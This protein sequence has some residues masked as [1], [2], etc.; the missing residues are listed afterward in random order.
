VFARE[1]RH[2]RDAVSLMGGLLT[3][4]VAG[5]FLL[6]DLTDVDMDA[7]WVGPAVLIAVGVAGLLST[8]RRRSP[9]P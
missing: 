2:D 6:V 5:L 8:L 3:V 9:S 7:R 4:L 1:Q